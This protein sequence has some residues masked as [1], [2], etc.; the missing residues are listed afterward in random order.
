MYEFEYLTDVTDSLGY[1]TSDTDYTTSDSLSNKLETNNKSICINCGSSEFYYD[2][3]TASCICVQCGTLNKNNYN[4][5]NGLDTS[6]DN[7]NIIIH[8]SST[9]LNKNSLIIKGIKHPYLKKFQNWNITTHQHRNTEITNK[10][11]KTY[12]KQLGL[13]KYVYDYV[14]IL[15]NNVILKNYSN[16]DEKQTIKKKISRGNNKKG[17]IAACTYYACKNTGYIRT[18]KEI[19]KVFNIATTCMN[20]GCKKFLKYVKNT[21]ISIN[22]NISK[23][24]D[25][26]NSMIYYFDIVNKDNFTEYIK[27][28]ENNNL[29]TKNKPNTIAIA[30]SI[31]Y[32]MFY[33]Y[34]VSNLNINEKKALIKSK[35]RIFN[36]S[37]TIIMN[38]CFALRKY[39]DF[40]FND[41]TNN[42]Y[43]LSE[44]K[45]INKE[46]IIEKQLLLINSLNPDDY[47]N[48]NNINIFDIVLRKDENIF[49]NNFVK[50]LKYF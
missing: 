37:G 15:Y 45:I 4:L 7:T 40:L 2:N 22:I 21:N 30:A 34:D 31:N 23:P 35:A 6:N 11:I 13:N 16:L 28:I 38:V 32:W 1:N 18:P 50:C 17:F 14:I 8:D 41:N 9:Q 39:D 26:I 12:C 27:K 10:L 46:D 29:I 49:N 24:S 25:F 47:N 44:K 3:H 20:N 36:T 5:N 19:S 43:K 33:I 48:I 42:N